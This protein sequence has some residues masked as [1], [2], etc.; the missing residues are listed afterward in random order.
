MA[1]LYTPDGRIVTPDEAMQDAQQVPI[2]LVIQQLVEAVNGLAQRMSTVNSIVSN[3]DVTLYALVESLM[4]KELISGEELTK[5]AQIFRQ[6]MEQELRDRGVDVDAIKR[7][8]Q[9]E[10]S[11]E[12]E[13]SETEEGVI[14][15]PWSKSEGT[16][17]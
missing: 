13:G 7:R 9:E 5:H 3:H 6:K 17:E 8:A 11:N 12:E 14:G 15:N 2:E 1:E 4:E 10:N 16:E